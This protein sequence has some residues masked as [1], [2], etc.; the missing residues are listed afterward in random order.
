MVPVRH[1]VKLAATAVVAVLALAG[2]THNSDE[3]LRVGDVSVPNAQIDADATGVTGDL[4]GAGVTGVTGQVRSALVELRVFN[5]VARRYA[6][7]QGITPAAADY[8]GTASNMQLPQTSQFVR[9]QAES[10]AL[11]TALRGKATPR[12]PTEAEIQQVY[13]A[14]L[15]ATGSTPADVP[16]D[17]VKSE[18][19]QMPEY[20]ESLGLRDA[21]EQAA[22]RYGVTINPRYQPLNHSLL[23]VSLNSG[24][25]LDLVSMPLG[26]QGTGAVTPAS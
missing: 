16:Y 10:E 23:T 13:D 18:L 9:L 19:L 6:Q 5:E 17:S 12:Q 14:F 24:G 7:E 3:A 8:A 26:Q 20:S 15:K 25:T 22:N 21:L 1:K 2:C 4:T 11:V